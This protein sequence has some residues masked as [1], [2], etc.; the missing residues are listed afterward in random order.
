MQPNLLSVLSD[1]GCCSPPEQRRQAVWI[2]PF[3]SLVCLFFQCLIKPYASIRF[4]DPRLGRVQGL[5]IY[6]KKECKEKARCFYHKRN[7]ICIFTG[8]AVIEQH[9]NAYY[10]RI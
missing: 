4:F 2:V 1:L 5:K 3:F 7:F 8:I 6:I 10:N 9:D